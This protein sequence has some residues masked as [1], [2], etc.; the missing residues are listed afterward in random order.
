MIA[1]DSLVDRQFWFALARWEDAPDGKV[2]ARV[3]YQRGDAPV[4]V[5]LRVLVAP[6][7]LRAQAEVLGLVR[8]AEF[9]Q[10]EHDLPV[11]RAGQREEW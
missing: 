7:L 11:A 1:L 10:D 3:V 4:R 5:V 8:Q 6:L 2:V 9:R